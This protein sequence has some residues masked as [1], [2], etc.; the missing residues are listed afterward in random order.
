MFLGVINVPSVITFLGLILAVVGSILALN[1]NLPGAMVCLMF[2]GLCDFFDG[3]VARKMNLSEKEQAFG[4]H[5]D[6]IV[7]MASFGVAPIVIA[8]GFGLGGNFFDMAL[9]V[10]FSCCAAMRLAYFNVYGLE[11][12]GKVSFYTGLPVT[13]A[14]L[15]IPLVAMVYF[16]VSAD[17]F[18]NIM[19]GCYFLIAVLFVLKIPVPKPKGIF[20]LI[21]PLSAIGVSAF[22]LIQ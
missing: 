10:A 7:D 1:Q 19:R 13:F 17:M 2:A 20:Y 3:M 15:I 14:A 6:S 12:S 9:L 4:M 16:Y 21:F 22:Y 8:V 5:L 11:E 18:K